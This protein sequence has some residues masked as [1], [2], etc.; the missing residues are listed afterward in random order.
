[1]RNS[2]I[3]MLP[4]ANNGGVPVIGT[5]IELLAAQPPESVTLKVKPTL[6]EEPAE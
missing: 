5:T 2:L 1:M 4:A 3:K 6:P